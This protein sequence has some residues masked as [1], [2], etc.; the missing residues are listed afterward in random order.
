MRLEHRLTKRQILALY[1]N[2]A[3]YGNQVVGAGRAS[4]VYF[5]VQPSLLTVAQATFLAA[6]PQRPTAYNPYKD[7]RPAHRRQRRILDTL[8]HQK[9]ISPDEAHTAR[10]EQ[11][12][13]EPAAR[14][15]AAPHFV[16]MVLAAQGGSETGTSHDNARRHAA[17][18]GRRHRSRAS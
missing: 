7:P 10:N 2:V 17:G 11:L 9:L 5:G 13:I 1:L 3:P 14:A 4:E 8:V 16:E 6:L 12:R 15:F 18:D